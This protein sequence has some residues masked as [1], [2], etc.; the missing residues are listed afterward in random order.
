MTW[1]QIQAEAL[2]IGDEVARRR[3]DLELTEYHSKSRYRMAHPEGRRCA[4]TTRL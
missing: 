4:T 2:S 3:S 1:Q